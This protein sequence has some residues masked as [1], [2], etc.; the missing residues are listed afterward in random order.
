MVLLVV[1][2]LLLLLLVLRL[3]LRH[4]LRAGLR[5]ALRLGPVADQGH[6]RPL[7]LVAAAL[8]V[9]GHRGVAPG[10]E[11]GRLTGVRRFP[12]RSNGVCVALR[13]RRLEVVALER[14]VPRER[15]IP[16]VRG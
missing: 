10:G 3:L 9:E 16:G 4:G 14:P 15:P 7:V 8:V 11:G 1:L 6:P 13:R 12:L 2:L 5:R